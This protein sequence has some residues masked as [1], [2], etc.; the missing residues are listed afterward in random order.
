MDDYRHYISIDDL[1]VANGYYLVNTQ[2]IRMDK[3]MTL[4]LETG[5]WNLSSS[6]M[7]TILIVD[8]IGWTTFLTTNAYTRQDL[9]RILTSLT[10]VKPWQPA[11]E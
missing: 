3:L 1:M 7:A 6:N 9:E 10:S 11:M 2:H 5:R 8:G 4:S